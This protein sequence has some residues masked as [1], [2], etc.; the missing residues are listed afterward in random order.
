[1]DSIGPVPR[2]EPEPAVG[3][4]VSDSLGRSTATSVRPRLTDQD[5]KTV[6]S[7][8][9][10]DLTA[11]QAKLTELMVMLASIDLPTDETPFSEE[12]GMA[13]VRNTAHVYTDMSLADELA[14]M[15]ADPDFIDRA[16]LVAADVRR[17]NAA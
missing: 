5:F 10:Y 14:L 11:A 15:G 17:R 2:P 16:L 4:N 9:R 1:M 7:K 13:F 6:A 12:K 8:I 3:S